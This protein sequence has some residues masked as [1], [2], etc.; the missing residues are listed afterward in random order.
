VI[1]EALEKHF[2]RK[3]GLA[4]GQGDTRMTVE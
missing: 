2:G 3:T 1:E 4:A